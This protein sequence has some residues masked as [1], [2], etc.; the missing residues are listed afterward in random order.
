MDIRDEKDILE[1]R[2]IDDYKKHPMINFA[3][4]INRSMIWNF[5]ELTKG[6]CLTRIIT[7]IVII[8]IPF[9]LILLYRF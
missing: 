8:G 9:L 5:G 4:S 7:T 6:S 1:K 3:D 2:Q